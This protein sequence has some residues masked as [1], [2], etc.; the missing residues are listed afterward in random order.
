MWTTKF[1]ART[2]DDGKVVAKK[3]VVRMTNLVV[4][5]TNLV[6]HPYFFWFLSFSHHKNHILWTTKIVV[7]MTNLVVHMANLVVPARAHEMAHE[8][9]HDAFFRSFCRFFAQNPDIHPAGRW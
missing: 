6:V 5:M 2:K 8:M 4:H 9:V 7:R 1:P 3:I